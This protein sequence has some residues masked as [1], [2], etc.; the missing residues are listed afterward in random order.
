MP[1]PSSPSKVWS[2]AQVR[3]RAAALG[4]VALVGISAGVRGQ[5]PP[6]PSVLQAGAGCAVRDA[7]NGVRP[8]PTI[9]TGTP[10]VATFD[11]VWSII[12]RSHWDTTYNGVN[13]TLVR[14]TLRP[15]ALLAGSAAD[16]RPVLRRML[17]T[18][19]Q[20]HFSIIPGGA[21]HPSFRSE[22]GGIGVTVR[23]A[24]PYVLVTRVDA[25]GP[26]ARA[27]VRP[28]FEVLAVDGC[29]L[30]RRAEFAVPGGVRQL[31]ANRWRETVALLRGAV[32]DSVRVSFRNATGR[33][34]AVALV[35]E[36]DAGV[37]T[38]VG[39]LPAVSAQLQWERRSVG[40]RSVGII[41]FN[42]WMPVLYAGIAAAVDSL[43]NADAI[44][45][46]LRG[47]LGGIGAMSQG[48]AG[49]F[50]DTAL[51]LGTMIQRGA[52]QQYLIN[53]QRVNAQ[54]QRVVPFGGAL[55]IVVDELSVSTTEIFAGGLQ[56]L[57][58]AW[59][60][61]TQTAGQA[62]PSVAEGLPN[63]DILYHAIANF[64]GRS[65]NAIEGAG[66][67]PNVVVP[68]QRSRLLNGEDPALD[69]AV[70][71]AAAQAKPPH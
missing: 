42:I 9:A 40:T 4:A 13:W 71:W 5:K 16:L 8:S 63:G 22:P 38:Q 28:G 1:S 15:G 49:H 25:A 55:A 41:R 23:D 17:S 37:P 56:A 36:P 43:R 31:P 33:V 21:S 58:R 65:G 27:G 68:V 46:D 50:V 66:V 7:S 34:V 61:G 2:T 10:P 3:R 67:T 53:P 60:F 14:D 57:G 44:V 18:L 24:T 54:N 62:L 19:G 47:N 11:S 29:A 70:K 30:R 26:A 64:L 59:V 6:P 35:R 39:N 51:T 48:V 52:T 45:L 12:A 69:V 32:G 20:S